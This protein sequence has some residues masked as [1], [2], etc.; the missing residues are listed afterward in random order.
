MTIKKILK[1]LLSLRIV[2]NLSE[3]RLLSSYNQA[4]SY[5]Y[6]ESTLK[7][8]QYMSSNT[9]RNTAFEL[10]NEEQ[11]NHLKETIAKDVIKILIKDG[12]IE[13]NE[14]KKDEINST[15][16]IASIW[17]GKKEK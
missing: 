2:S 7:F 3:K 13:F 6:I 9:V 8:K 10:I 17:V 11:R 4:S 12:Y 16:I 1:Y 15:K 5:L 14:I